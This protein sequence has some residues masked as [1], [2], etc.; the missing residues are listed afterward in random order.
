M[1]KRPGKQRSD[2]GPRC[3]VVCSQ[4]GVKANNHTTLDAADDVCFHE[5]AD[6][7]GIFRM[8]SK[9]SHGFPHNQ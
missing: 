4:G 5:V 2:Y 1:T 7:D 6:Y 9:Q 8:H 3:K